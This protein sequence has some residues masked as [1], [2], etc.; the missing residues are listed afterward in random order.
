MQERNEN[1]DTA[2]VAVAELPS[3]APDLGVM[4]DRILVGPAAITIAQAE[5]FAKRLRR[6]IN[7]AKGK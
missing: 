7:I 2:G 1:T 5:Q 4:G 6:M 3:K